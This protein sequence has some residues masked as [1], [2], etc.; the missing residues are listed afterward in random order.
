MY[1]LY[2]SLLTIGL[3]IL[4]PRFVIDAFRG[5]KYVTGLRERF[6]GLRNAAGPA[7]IIWVHC[8]SVG[9]TEAARPLV[10]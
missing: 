1:L 7:P 9:E 5:G 3:F 6:G 2:S 10:Q 8:V 4:L